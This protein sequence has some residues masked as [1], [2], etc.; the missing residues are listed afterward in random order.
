VRVSD[1]EYDPDGYLLNGF[2]YDL[3]VWVRNGRILDCGHPAAMRANGPCCNA[4]R[5]AGQSIRTA[6]LEM[7]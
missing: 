6:H 2:D 3:Q 7:L 1:D 4:H 5:L